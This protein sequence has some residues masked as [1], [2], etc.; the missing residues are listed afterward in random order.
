M[1]DPVSAAAASHVGL[2]AINAI[3]QNINLAVKQ[4]ARHDSLVAFTQA[5]RVE[6]LVL[7]DTAVLFDD[8][9]PDV[10]QSLSNIF[11]GYYLQAVSLNSVIG[12]TTVASVL[13]KFNPKREFD[14]LDLAAGTASAAKKTASVV[15]KVHHM[16]T[17]A[18]AYRDRLPTDWSTGIALE[19]QVKTGPGARGDRGGRPLD[20][21]DEKF[22]RMKRESEMQRLEREKVEH[23]RVATSFADDALELT[24][25]EYQPVGRQDLRGDDQARGPDVQGTGRDPSGRQHHSDRPAHSHS[26][27]QR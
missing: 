26:F 11:A 9:L 17:A 16:M 15:A 3:I 13:G 14:A 23:A 6:P 25:R 22:N 1:T 18:E 5:A 21:D 10:M 24:E 27:S 20:A 19:A 7:V 8:V 12:N 4:G 2:S